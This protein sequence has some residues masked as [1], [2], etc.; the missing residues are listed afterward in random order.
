MNDVFEI[1]ELGQRRRAVVL[2]AAIPGFTILR[3]ATPWERL[4]HRWQKL[5]DARLERSALKTA[6]RL[7]EQ[8]RA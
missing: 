2:V 7:I 6:Q 3:Y 4:C 5:R 1:E 8:V